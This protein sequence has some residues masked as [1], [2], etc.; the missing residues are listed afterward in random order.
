M[1]ILKVAILGALCVGSV[2]LPVHAQSI[3]HLEEFTIAVDN[4]KE[5]DLYKGYMTLDVATKNQ[6]VR[7]FADIDFRALLG[8]N[9]VKDGIRE[10][11]STAI[12]TKIR[13][14]LAQAYGIPVDKVVVP[15]QLL[16]SK[17]DSFAF[18]VDDVP[19]IGVENY[20]NKIV[21]TEAL[22][23]ASIRQLGISLNLIGCEKQGGVDVTIEV[24]KMDP[25]HFNP[26]SKFHSHT[27]EPAVRAIVSFG[28][29]VSLYTEVRND[30][31]GAVDSSDGSGI[32]YAQAL[33]SQGDGSILKY[34]INSSETGL[35]LRNSIGTVLGAVGTRKGESIY[36]LVDYR[37][38]LPGGI[39]V[40]IQ[41]SLEKNRADQVQQGSIHRTDVLAS[42]QLNKWLGVWGEYFIRSSSQNLKSSLKSLEFGVDTS[43]KRFG[44]GAEYFQTKEYGVTNRGAA[45]TGTIKLGKKKGRT[46]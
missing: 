17:L 32:G 5:I 15:P 8:K 7:G 31:L 39:A 24:G 2:H 36:G 30:R 33:V 18:E 44:V 26:Q 25:L 38:D 20:L 40:A 21:S 13:M 46:R 23:D 45:V 10:K 1:N 19:G 42:K 43:I 6:C 16:Q 22:I 29:R 28:E 14:G 11:I 27:S 12:E 9:K 35:I 3:T 34:N 37:T 41:Y 4:E